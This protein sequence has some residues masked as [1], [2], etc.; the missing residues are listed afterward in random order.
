LYGQG[1]LSKKMTRDK[2]LSEPEFGSLLNAAESRKHINAPRDYTLLLTGGAAA[3]RVS[4][5][6]DIRAEDCTR[7]EDRPHPV[8][9]V[10][11]RKKREKVIYEVGIPVYAAVVLQRWLDSCGATGSERLFPLSTRS[12]QRVFKLYARLAGL[13][14]EYSIHSLRHFR[15]VHL[16]EKTKN[17]LVV[18]ETLRHASI[19][20]SEV[21]MHAVELRERQ[22]AADIDWRGGLEPGNG[23]QEGAVPSKRQ[24]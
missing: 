9:L 24:D 21:Y 19:R 1:Y 17:L 7:L 13:R 16:Y 11:T 10:R 20:S 14:P 4:E 2:W 8:L 6:V 5:L 18:K 15:G 3:M 22:V 12:A 23:H